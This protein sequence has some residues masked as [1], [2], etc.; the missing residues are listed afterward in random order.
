M[1]R[2]ACLAA[3]SAI[4]LMAAGRAHAQGIP[5]Y[6]A[7]LNID[8]QTN[9]ASSLVNEA[10]QITNQVT[11]ITTAANQLTQAITNAE[12]LTALP[13]LLLQFQIDPALLQDQQLRMLLNDVYTLEADAAS[14][15]ADVNSL[16]TQQGFQVALTIPQVTIQA[17]NV[18]SP[19]SANQFSSNYTQVSNNWQHYQQS[20]A[21]MS[22]AQTQIQNQETALQNQIQS[23]TSLTD[24]SEVATLQTMLAGQTLQAQ[25]LDSL[26]KL[27]NLS[28]DAALQAEEQKASDDAAIQQEGLTLAQTINTM[29]SQP[30]PTVSS[31]PDAP[32][33]N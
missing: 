13:S 33:A 11:Q 19:A 32:P 31:D 1:T 5:V 18:Y 24:N 23:A 20:A 25:Q 30:Y 3:V 7:T 21:A 29:I 2:T 22:D 14:F 4:A 16:A 6:D 27:A 28:A 17:G 9:W 26:V 12:R 8:T 10:N 15:N